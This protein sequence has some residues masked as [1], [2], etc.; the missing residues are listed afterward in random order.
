MIELLRP[1][2]PLAWIPLAIIWFG[3][4]EPSKF[5]VI[6]LGAFFKWNSF[7][8]AKVAAAR[9]FAFAESDRKTGT[10]DFADIDCDFISL[11]HLPKWH[12]FG[13]TR[14]FDNLSVQIRY[15]MTSRD[16]AIE[17][18]RKTGF[19]IPVDDVR[20]FCEFQGLPESWFWQTLEKF[21]NHDIWIRDGDVWKIPG[22]L[23]DDWDWA[24]CP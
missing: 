3:L 13:I 21:R 7:E 8:N 18:L 12:K 9:G 22:F 15:V 20:Q 24:A 4:G 16:A 1:I 5:F 10:W 11:H 23:I 14:A 19:Q 6:F 2:P 17:Y